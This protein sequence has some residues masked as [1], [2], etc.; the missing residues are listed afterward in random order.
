MTD[1]NLFKKHDFVQHGNS[2]ASYLPG[3]PIFEAAFISGSNIRG[4]L[5]GFALELVRVEQELINYILAYGLENSLLLS[6]FESSIGIPDVCF[7]ATGDFAD[8]TAKVFAKLASNGVQTVE[9]FENIATILGISVTVIPG[10]DAVPA[11]SDPKFTIV[12]EHAL[13]ISD[14]FAYDFPFTFRLSDISVL[15]CLFEKLKPANCRVL[16]VEV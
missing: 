3:G 8:R 6:E 11:V 13:D 4:L 5:E 15:E 12:I 14:T 2:L 7:L 10:I 1:F 9:D 16:F